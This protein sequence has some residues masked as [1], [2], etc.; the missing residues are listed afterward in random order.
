MRL[1]V[2]NSRNAREGVRGGLP[3][4][5]DDGR[6]KRPASIHEA[7]HGRNAET[8]LAGR[9]PAKEVGAWQEKP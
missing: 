6:Q 4:R 8:S 1:G 5:A 2:H 3:T 9:I 7:N